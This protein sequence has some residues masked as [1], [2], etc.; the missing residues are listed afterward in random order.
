MV[1]LQHKEKCFV[2]LQDK[3]HFQLTAIMFSSLFI[4]TD[5]FNAREYLRRLVSQDFSVGQ[6]LVNLGLHGV[7]FHLVNLQFC[8][9]LLSLFFLQLVPFQSCTAAL[10]P[11]RCVNA[12]CL[13]GLMVS[14]SEKNTIPP[15]HCRCPAV[16]YLRYRNYRVPRAAEV[17]VVFGSL[18]DHRQ[19]TIQVPEI[20][21]TR[22]P[23]LPARFNANHARNLE[24]GSVVHI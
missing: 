1:Q 21:P 4:L 12:T 20:V 16:H 5:E 22:F 6:N 13:Y 3:K 23:Q 17:E 15:R 10:I 9:M 24:R 18:I 2:C 14:K 11:I 8:I 7:Y 19:T